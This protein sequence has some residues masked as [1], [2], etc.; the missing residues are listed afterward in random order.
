MYNDYEVKI[1]T[2]Y[3][4][5]RKYKDCFDKYEYYSYLDG[6]YNGIIDRSRINV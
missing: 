1:F 3:H 5:L 2:F 6:N 4:L